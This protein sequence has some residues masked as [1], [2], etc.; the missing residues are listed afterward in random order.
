MRAFSREFRREVLAACDAGGKRGRGVGALG[1]GVSEF[2]VRLIKQD[3]RELG[4]T[5]QLLTRRRPPKWRAGA[6]RIRAAIR[7]MPDW[8]LDELKVHLGTSLGR[9]TLCRSLQVLRLTVKKES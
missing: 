4:K 7:Q 2:W 5:A 1:F 9:S 6:D 3:R 8:T